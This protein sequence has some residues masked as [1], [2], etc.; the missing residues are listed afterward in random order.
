M[1]LKT[2]T[3]GI[4]FRPA[5]A[6]CLFALL[7]AAGCSSIG[8]SEN[9]TPSLTGRVLAA[10]TRLPLRGVTV[11]RVTP[12]QSAG[13]P[14]KGG[15][16]LVEGRPEITGADGVFVV[17]GQSYAKL[18][19]HASGWSVRLAFQAPGYVSWRTNFTS[20]SFTNQAAT[21]AGT[22]GVGEVLLAPSPK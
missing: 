12:G 10:E 16:L 2:A 14:T 6:G 8:P 9:V 19:L 3:A 1:R 15:Q 22:V 20:A 11:T 13:A 4:S 5:L 7:L 21:G 17:P 18:F